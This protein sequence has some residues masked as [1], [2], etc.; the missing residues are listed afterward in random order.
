LL[1]KLIAG[2]LGR[3]VRSAGTE[4]RV[5]LLEAILAAETQALTAIDD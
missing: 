1:R 3:G 2:L 4:E 5:A